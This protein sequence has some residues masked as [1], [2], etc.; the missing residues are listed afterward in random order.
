MHTDNGV[1]DFDADSSSL[2]LIKIP[3]KFKGKKYLLIEAL[4]DAVAKW[5]NAQIAGATLRQDDRDEKTV[6]M[7]NMADS[8]IL[9][10]GQCLFLTNTE[11]GP[12]LQPNGDLQLNARVGASVVKTWPSRVVSQLYDKVMD[13]SGLT[14]RETVE[15]L[16]R[17][18]ADLQKRRD[19][20][21][22]TAAKDNGIKSEEE[23]LAKN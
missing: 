6:S 2:D 5:K 18:I 23:A 14:G 10:V 20:L 3:V 7:G 12:I 21:A 4:A 19:R 16:D 1:L 8:E 15:S 13:I 11:G 17:K 22:E 9:L